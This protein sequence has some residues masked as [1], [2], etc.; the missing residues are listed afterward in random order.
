M[1]ASVD[2]KSH[3]PH[4]LDLSADGL[5]LAVGGY[6]DNHGHAS[7]YRLDATA[8]AV[9]LR[10][11]IVTGTIHASALS[12]DGQRL[13]VG[14]WGGGA[15]LVFDTAT[16]GM[17]ARQGAA[18]ASRIS[19]IAFSDDGANLASA[20]DQGTIKIW[21]DGRNL[22][23]KSTVLLTLKG[24]QAQVN[25]LRL[26]NGGKRLFAASCAPKDGRPGDKTE[27]PA[28]GT[29]KTRVRQ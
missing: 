11:E 22:T 14:Q 15:L 20:D 4:Y 25:R 13:A 17:I 21:A 29:W 10:A 12:P 18:T 5:T 19:A 27:R 8:K 6:G 24:H 28:S 9:T 1:I 7:I 2:R 23:S 26:S 3:E 16:G